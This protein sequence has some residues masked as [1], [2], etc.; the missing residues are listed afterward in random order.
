MS[1]PATPTQHHR[2]RRRPFG[3]LAICGLLI[4]QAV[5]LGLAVIALAL[6]STD[7]TSGHIT[8]TLWGFAVDAVSDATTL[9]RLVVAVLASLIAVTVLQVVL[10]LALRRAGWVLT[11]LLTGLSLAGQLYGIWRGEPTNPL[12]LFLD[13][14]TALY[15]NQSEVR[16]AFGVSAGRLDAAL[17]RSADAVVDVAMGD[18]AGLEEVA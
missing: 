5:V 15:L 12:A 18:G 8:L 6:E 3:V 9:Q 13:S 4:F 11:M 14:V 7:S 17:G 1:G 2:P 16:R 10:L